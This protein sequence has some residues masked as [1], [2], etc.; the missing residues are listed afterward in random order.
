M[1]N[2]LL[3]CFTWNT[4]YLRLLSYLPVW[5]VTDLRVT[6]RPLAPAGRNMIYDL[7]VICHL[8]ELRKAIY[9][10]SIKVNSDVYEHMPHVWW[11]VHEGVSGIPL[12]WLCLNHCKIHLSKLRRVAA[13][14]HYFVPPPCECRRW[15]KKGGVLWIGKENTMNLIC[16]C[17]E[18]WSASSLWV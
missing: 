7:F 6:E 1:F 17:Y 18:L 10:R 13:G 4:E 9:S 16:G 2:F 5:Q 11:H 3:F 14:N 8:F 15:G 12:T